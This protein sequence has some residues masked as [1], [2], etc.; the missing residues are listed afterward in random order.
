[1]TESSRF[2]IGIF[3]GTFAFGVSWWSYQGDSAPAAGA[4]ALLVAFLSGYTLRGSGSAEA[5][6]ETEP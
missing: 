3:G 5:A 2:L 6:R 4:I 1:M